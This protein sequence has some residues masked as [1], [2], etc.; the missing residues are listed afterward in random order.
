M[1]QGD[2]SPTQTFSDLLFLGALEKLNEFCLHETKAFTKIKAVP[3]TYRLQSRGVYN[4]AVKIQRSDYLNTDQ[5]LFN[6]IAS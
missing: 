1:A 2:T 3:A 4:Q 6:K 5:L